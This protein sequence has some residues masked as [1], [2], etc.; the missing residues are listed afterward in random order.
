MQVLDDGAF[1][2]TRPDGRSFDSPAPQATG[3]TELVANQRVLIT[4][5]TAVTRWT[6]EAFDAAQAV[7]R[8][9]RRAARS[10]SVSAET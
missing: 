7:D 6:G 8:L 3:W 1:R 4:P 9:L 5:Q 2:F 10:K